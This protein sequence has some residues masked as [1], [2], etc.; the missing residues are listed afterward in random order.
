MRNTKRTRCRTG[1]STRGYLA[2]F[3]MIL[4][5]GF[6]VLLLGGNSADARPEATEKYYT[7]VT[8]QAGDTLWSIAEQ[9]A[10]EY[11]DIRAYVDQLIRINRLHNTESL[12]PGQSLVIVYYR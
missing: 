9:Y 7:S 4:S 2:A 8:V 6:S 3:L 1:R 5:L 10:P 12:R 11:S